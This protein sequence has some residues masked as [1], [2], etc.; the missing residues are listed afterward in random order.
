[1]NYFRYNVDCF[2]DKDRFLIGVYI[3]HLIPILDD[4]NDAP[5][6][7]FHFTFDINW[8][9]SSETSFFYDTFYNL[10]FNI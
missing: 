5:L 1:M 4:V 7:S 6:T 2:Y 3:V 9:N 8:T 10:S